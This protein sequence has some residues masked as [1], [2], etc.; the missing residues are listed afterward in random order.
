[1]SYFGYVE[2]AAD[3]YINWADVGR[4]MS[5]TIDNV[6]QARQEKRDAIET[7]F[8]EDMEYIKA[9]VSG[10]N[11]DLRQWNMDFANNAAEM[12]K[13]RYNMLK[14]GQINVKDFTS[15]RENL[16]GGTETLYSVLAD[17]QTRWSEAIERHK[18]GDS[19]MFEMMQ[20]E[21]LERFGNLQNTEAYINDLNGSLAI[22]LTEEVEIDGKKVRRLKKDPNAYVTVGEL[23]AAANMKFDNFDPMPELKA[24]VD[25]HG[26]V[27]DTLR[28]IGAATKSGAILK[29]TDIT[30]NKYV[31]KLK[32]AGIEDDELKNAIAAVEQFKD[33]KNEFYGSILAKDF[34][35]LAIATDQKKFAPNGK[36]YTP[37]Y[38]P[39]DLEGEKKDV[40]HF[41]LMERVN[42][43]P[44][45]KFT[46][47][48]R[49]DLIGYLDKLATPMFDRK[50]ELSTY[51]EQRPER[52]VQPSE[53][54][55]ARGDAAKRAV[56][57]AS[58]I[59]KLYGGD[60]QTKEQALTTLRGEPGVEQAYF[61]KI[62]GKTFLHI[63][64]ADKVQDIPMTNADGTPAISVEDFG[65]SAASWIYGGG[66]R[67]ILK[68]NLKDFRRTLAD[69]SN[70]QKF[71]AEND[72]FWKERAV[73]EPKIENPFV[74]KEGQ[75]VVNVTQETAASNIN[76]KLSELGLG[77]EY[78]AVP[79][80][81]SSLGFHEVTV[82][83]KGKKGVEV[84]KIKTK[85]PVGNPNAPVT[86][87]T[88]NNQIKKLVNKKRANSIPRD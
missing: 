46:D 30:G 21:Q 20:Y 85:W 67:N 17:V 38:N 15:F 19:Q 43:I 24:W 84:F 62:G 61:K 57:M 64:T 11:R 8:N 51:A 28:M 74:A 53:G 23:K 9:Q 55:M 10:E 22:G 63:E 65:E 7:A 81:T 39:K 41:I 48:Q 5:E 86:L 47:D 49:D 37:T 31:E 45:P 34:D 2:R 73:E 77:D 59:G 54:Q 58:W 88:L 71:G 87:E 3:S 80:A 78:E 79:T 68:E 27:V 82:K 76:A 25:S 26:D 72:E 75:S 4:N 40:E 36:Q 44:K 12:Y 33:A 29:V 32:Q 42:G 52:P 35:A 14:S 70:W 13:L 6:L 60:A 1:M 18:N 66:D 50:S 69:Y 56:T 16:I 83:R